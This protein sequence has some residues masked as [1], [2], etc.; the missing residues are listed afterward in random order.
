LSDG[1]LFFYIEER[2]AYKLGARSGRASYR[3]GFLFDC[4]LGFL[5]ICLPTCKNGSLFISG[6][7]TANRQV[8]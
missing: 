6:A 5:S 1:I 4:E 7:Y 3:C 8:L 2:V